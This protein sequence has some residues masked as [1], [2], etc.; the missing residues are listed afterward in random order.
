MADG[1]KRL[2]IML[3]VVTLEIEKIKLMNFLD[4]WSKF[5][6]INKNFEQKMEDLPI[7]ILVS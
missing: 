1:V 6:N 2:S 4:A 3:K 7:I 5:L